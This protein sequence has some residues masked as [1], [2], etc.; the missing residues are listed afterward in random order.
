MQLLQALNRMWASS[1]NLVAVVR[2][3]H[4]LLKEQ[5]AG[6]EPAKRVTKNGMLR[7]EG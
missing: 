2:P 3:L 7:E 5:L 6:I 4:K 1:T